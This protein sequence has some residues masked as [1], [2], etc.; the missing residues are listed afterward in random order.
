MENE[1]KKAIVVPND[2][3]FGEVVDALGRGETVTFTVKGWSMFPFLRDGK[4]AVRIQKADAPLRKGDVILFRFR[5]RY[6]LHRI[7]G[8]RRKDG[9]PCL[10]VTMGDGNVR[11]EEFAADTSVAGVMTGKISPAGKEWDCRSMS[12]RVLSSVWMRLRTVR[13]WCLAILRRICR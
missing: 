3:F 12:L 11:G 2:V 8:I 6:V 7:Y 5:G 4:D 13:R 9:E 1:G 10:Y